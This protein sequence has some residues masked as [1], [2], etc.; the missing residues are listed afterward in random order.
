MLFYKLYHKKLFEGK[1]FPQFDVLTKK[2]HFENFGLTRFCQMRAVLHLAEKNEPHSV[3]QLLG[4]IF[5]SIRFPLSKIFCASETQVMIF[6]FG[7]MKITVFF[8]LW[9]HY[10]AWHDIL[11]LLKY[12]MNWM[13]V[14]EILSTWEKKV[15]YKV[16]WGNVTDGSPFLG[17]VPPFS[18]VP[19]F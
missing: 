5:L 2:T 18:D 12:I 10:Y 16:I 15:F 9:C 4:S 1:I 13:R 11:I 7:F 3:L 8:F 14:L 17:L 19:P 6:P